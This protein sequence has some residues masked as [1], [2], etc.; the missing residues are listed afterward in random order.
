MKI[1]NDIRYEWELKNDSKC[2]ECLHFQSYRCKQNWPALEGVYDNNA[3]SIINCAEFLQAITPAKKDKISY[4]QTNQCSK[5]MYCKRS[6]Y[7]G[8]DIC[9]HHNMYMKDSENHT[10]DNFKT[11]LGGY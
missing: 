4:R 7:Y 11:N 1:V 6:L 2:F 8:N 5:C 10:C 3:K 9:L